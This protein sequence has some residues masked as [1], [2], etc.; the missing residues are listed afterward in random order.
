MNFI[1]AGITSAAVIGLLATSLA[2]WQRDAHPAVGRL[3][4]PSTPV[5]REFF[6]LHIHRATSATPW[7]TVPFGSWR[8]WDAACAWTHLEPEKDKWTWDNLDKEVAL[9]EQHHVDLLLTFG[10]TPQWASARPDE[11]ER[12][13][14]QRPGGA[15]E[16][17]NIEDWRVFVRAVTSRYKGR[18]HYYEIWNE[19]NLK[20]FYSG[21]P[22]KMLE[23]AREAYPIIKQAD[24]SNQVVSPSAVGPTGLPWLE[25]YFELGGNKYADIIGYHFYVGMRPPEAMLDF[26]NPVKKLM[27]QYDIANK[28]LWNTEAGWLGRPGQARR[29]DLER[30]AP[31][32]VARAYL[33]NW[34]EGVQRFYWYAWDD[35]GF[36]NIP[37]TTEDDSSPTGAA[38][39][40]SEIQKWMIGSTMEFCQSEA[41]GNAMCKLQ[42]P[43]GHLAFVLW[44]RDRASTFDIPASWKIRTITQLSGIQS[45]YNGHNVETGEA[46]VL[47]EP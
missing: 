22:E 31:G 34:A 32:W 28:P 36:D 40:Y 41:G 15:A 30:E 16:P 27:Q 24:P 8:L 4:P 44:N 45:V 2:F 39:A 38:R 42:R 23:L 37:F 21:S 14:A 10:K 46:P 7:P 43:G 1:K 25:R 26:I 3:V 13:P 5:P 18:I 20:N 33:I 29:V 9:A 19:P 17:K 12:G 6:G 11:G 35:K 47:L